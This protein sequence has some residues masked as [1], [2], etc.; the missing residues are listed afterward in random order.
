MVWG[1]LLVDNEG[2]GERSA[3]SESLKKACQTCLE[4]I[5]IS[6]F[7]VCH[8]LSFEFTQRVDVQKLFFFLIRKIKIIAYKATPGELRF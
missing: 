6:A 3:I 1:C 5:N 2:E 4:K 7:V 8:G